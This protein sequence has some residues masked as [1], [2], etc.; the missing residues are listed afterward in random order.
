VSEE[1][2]VFPLEGVRILDFTWLGAGAKS[3]RHLAAYGAEVIRIEWKGK[4]DF[5]RLARPYQ[6]AADEDPATTGDSVNR[7]AS[8]NNLNPGK[9]GISLNLRHPKGKELFRSLLPKAD[10]VLDNYTADT[11]KDWGFGY[12]VMDAI[13]PGII[14]VQSPGFGYRGPY[15]DYR[16]YGPTAAAV[17]GITHMAGLPDRYPS[18]WGFSYMD[19][20]TPW[21]IAIAVLACLRYRERTGKGQWIDLSQAGPGYLLTGTALLDYAVNGREYVRTGNRSPYLPAAPHGAYPCAGEEAWVAIA[22]FS[23]DDWR[24]LVEALGNP[25]WAGQPRFATLDGRLANQDALDACLGE[26]TRGWD[27]YALMEVLQGAGVAAGVCQTPADRFDTDPQ[28]R[29]RGE[30]RMVSHA[31]LGEY[32]VEEV[33][34]RWSRTQ[35]HT[36][37]TEGRGAP[38]Y[39]EHNAR[40][41]GELLGLGAEELAALRADDVI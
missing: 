18:G 13:R 9:L 2:T 5:L 22:C 19:V 32:A 12:E 21:N 30:Y 40:V 7:S 1:A 8:F 4:M 27:R 14:Y 17:A 29:A 41:Y 39:G 36:G 35:P 15:R 10:V 37:G 20:V 33:P 38:C 6:L 26:T 34:S 28:H 3:T 31:E 24:R 16:S 25:S 23:D 11:L